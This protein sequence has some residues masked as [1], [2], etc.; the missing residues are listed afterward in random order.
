MKQ[1][2]IS[3][4]GLA[5][6]A[7]C[8]LA[9]PWAG[10]QTPEVAASA[11]PATP[12]YGGR[13]YQIDHIFVMADPAVLTARGPTT[14]DFYWWPQDTPHPGQGTTGGYFYFDN[15]YIE[16]LAV[17][18]PAEAL[19]NAGR[20]GVNLDQRGDWKS[21]SNVSPFG[22]GLRDTEEGD[23]GQPDF[24]GGLD[25]Y[26][27]DWMHGE[28]SLWL[29]PATRDLAQPW[30]FFMPLEQTGNPRDWMG[31]RAARLLEHPGGARVL[32]DLLLVS[33]PDAPPSETLLA[34]ERDGT[35]RLATGDAFLIELTFDGGRQGRTLDLRPQGSPMVLRY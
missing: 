8:A 33:P 11:A 6:L 14:D 7:T 20:T 5:M 1:S 15:F 30:A 25:R 4:L 22:I 19:A 9:A 28:F 32:T 27:A 2:T 3:I 24:F 35:L 10:A 26:D 23:D 21:R 31:P 18:D 17:T 13:R 12:S 29:T 34:L 16:F